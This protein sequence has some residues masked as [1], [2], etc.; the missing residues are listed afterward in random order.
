MHRL[1]MPMAGKNKPV[2]VRFSERWQVEQII[3]NKLKLKGYEYKGSRISIVQDY[4]K[5]T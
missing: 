5:P 3:S 2:I 1:G 4:S